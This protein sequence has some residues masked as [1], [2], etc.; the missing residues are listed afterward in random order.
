MDIAKLMLWILAAILLLNYLLNTMLTLLNLSNL[1]EK[2]P[3]GLEDLYD[4]EKYQKSQQ[5][6]KDK[7]RFSLI[8]DSFSFVVSF[9]FLVVGGYAW[10]DEWT[11]T[12]TTDVMWATLLFFG[13]LALVS[14]LISIPF[15]LYSVFIIEERYGFNRMTIGTFISDKIKGYLLGG[16]LGGSLLAMFVLFYQITGTS[17][18][19]YML[20]VFSVFIIIM[21][22]F[23]A[24]WI[25][26][27]FNKLTP[28][29]Q[30]EVRDAIESYC[31]KNNFEL[32]NLYVMDGSKRSAKANAFFSGLGRKKKIVLFDTL[33]NNY[34]KDELVAV[35]AHEVGHYKKKHTLWSL[36]LSI[37]QMTL[38]L[39]LL[40]FFINNKLFSEALGSVDYSLALSLIAFVLLYTPLSIIT[41]ILMNMFSRKNEFEADAFAGSTFHAEALISALKKLSSDS[42]SNLSPHPWYVF[43]YYSHPPL[44]QRVGALTSSL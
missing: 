41:G 40:S 31:R 29:P 16:M 11:H 4:K 23:Y 9:L 25:L 20:I 39:Y 27:L 26:P 1:S 42:L 30:G 15:S 13:M 34:S 8:S 2:P 38:M 17:F 36:L 7:S 43:F 19:I 44:A 22:A 33:V 28:L 6:E 32:S 14:D 37:L 5:Y 24:S 10:L 18:W 12:V 3:K 21:N 35:L